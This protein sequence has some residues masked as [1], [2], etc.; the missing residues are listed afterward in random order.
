MAKK[1]VLTTIANASPV[2]LDFVDSIC[3][4]RE[5]STLFRAYF[6]EEASLNPNPNPNPNHNSDLRLVVFFST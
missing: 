5:I 6:G 4:G 1:G 2:D 3:F